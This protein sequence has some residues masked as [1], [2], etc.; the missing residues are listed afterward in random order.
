MKQ[1]TLT[2]LLKIY[3][4]CYLDAG[5]LLGTLIT[6]SPTS[7]PRQCEKLTGTSINLHL[8]IFFVILI[9]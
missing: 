1:K 5:T 3:E 6:F 9:N 8:Y 2:S 7:Q 4:M